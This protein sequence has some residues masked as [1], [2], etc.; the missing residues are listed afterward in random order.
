M[1]R[2]IKEGHEPGTGGVPSQPAAPYALCV[3]CH[4]ERLAD[5]SRAFCS[6]KCR[7]EYGHKRGC[8]Q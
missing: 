6:D 8:V 5:K 7:E 4:E 1:E 2:E 3:N